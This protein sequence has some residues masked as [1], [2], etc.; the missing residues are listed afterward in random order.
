MVSYCG[1]LKGIMAIPAGSLGCVII[2]IIY[3]LVEHVVAGALMV[4]RVTSQVT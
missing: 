3:C 1:I 2:V 4:Q